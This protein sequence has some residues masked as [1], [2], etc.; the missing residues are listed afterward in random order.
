MKKKVRLVNGR[1]LPKRPFK[2]KKICNFVKALA[3]ANCRCR[4][5]RRGEKY[6][7]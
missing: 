5:C 4:T 2:E 1:G 6:H 3:H 7:D